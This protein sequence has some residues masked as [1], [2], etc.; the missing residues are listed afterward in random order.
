[1]LELEGKAGKIGGGKLRLSIVTG[2]GGGIAES[3]STQ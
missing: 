2:C 3:S 1:M